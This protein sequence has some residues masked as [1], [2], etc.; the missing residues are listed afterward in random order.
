MSKYYESSII[1]IVMSNI[2]MPNGDHEFICGEFTYPVEV[3]SYDGDEDGNVVWSSNQNLGSA[4]ADARMLVV[5][6]RGSLII[7]TGVTVTPQTRKRG[8]LLYVTDVLT[9][10]GTISMT[11][12]GASA[13]NQPVWLWSHENREIEII[14]GISLGGVHPNTANNTPGVS[15]QVGLNRKLGGGGSGGRSSN[16]TGRGG[17]S[18]SYSGGPG[19]G[20]GHAGTATQGSDTGGPGGNGSGSDGAGTSGGGA[21]NPG[22]SG[23]GGAGSAGTGGLLI[24]ACDEFYNIGTISSN[25]S[26]G[27]NTF[28]YSNPGGAAGGGSGGG[29]INIFYIKTFQQ[30]GTILANGGLGGN[31][32]TTSNSRGGNGGNGSITHTQIDPYKFSTFEYNRRFL[33]GRSLLQTITENLNKLLTGN[34]FLDFN[35]DVIYSAETV[36]YEG[37]YTWDNDKLFGEVQPQGVDH[38]IL[39]VLIK[40]NLKIN[41]GVTISAR[42]SRR[43]FMLVVLGTLENYG[44]INMKT[45]GSILGGDVRVFQNNNKSYETISTVQKNGIVIISTVR[46]INEGNL[47]LQG[48]SINLYYQGLMKLGNRVLKKQD[49]SP[50]ALIAHRII[51]ADRVDK[52][53]FG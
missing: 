32:L 33:E 14:N 11:A 50:N 41:E 31:A 29:S 27:A 26:N 8:F 49:G 51:D 24:I 13:P 53:T 35:E 5:I 1:N 3:L 12:R 15:G 23:P 17:N 20:G 38:R 30:Y 46:L 36:V 25:G 10:S 6:V 48:D 22:G 39:I 43:A 40:G 7:N 45:T 21:G 42:D 19:G 16:V 18:T 4:I 37:N 34:S 2:D 44:T 9:N 47:I 52:L 28:W